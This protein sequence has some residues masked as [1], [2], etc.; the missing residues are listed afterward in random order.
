MGTRS[1]Y[2]DRGQCGT[3]HPHLSTPPRLARESNL[4]V[5]NP[6]MLTQ[7]R[8]CADRGSLDMT[9]P[10][11]AAQRYSRRIRMRNFSEAHSGC[12]NMANPVGRITCLVEC[13][14]LSFS[15]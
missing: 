15:V 1:K 8:N 12:F 6:Q 13:Y 11:T 10:P 2:P 7:I 3:S 4:W 5:Q 14:A 9:P